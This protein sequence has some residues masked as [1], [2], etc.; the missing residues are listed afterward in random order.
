MSLSVITFFKARHSINPSCA[1][2]LALAAFKAVGQPRAALGSLGQIDPDLD[3]P[4][5]VESP[6]VGKASRG[7]AG[8]IIA[9][10]N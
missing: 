9:L 4:T 7:G 10:Q 2:Q 1:T 5:C 3:D 6:K 8:G